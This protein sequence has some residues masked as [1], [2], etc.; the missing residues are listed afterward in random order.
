MKNKDYETLPELDTHDIRYLH[1][2][3]S[4][5]LDTPDLR[6]RFVDENFDP[7]LNRSTLIRCE[8]KL[9]QF[10]IKKRLSVNIKNKPTK[11]SRK[12][13][14]IAIDRKK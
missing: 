7:K 12:S 9:K 8:F 14:S 4:E 1:S 5:I 10:L 11:C 2:L 3:C 13:S 6:D